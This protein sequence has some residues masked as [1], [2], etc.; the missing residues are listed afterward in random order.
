MRI[1]IVCG[2]IM[3]I[4]SLQ[5]WWLWN[6]SNIYANWRAFVIQ[7]GES[8]ETSN[9][10]FYLPYK[11]I[12]ARRFDAS[13]SNPVD[14]FVEQR[15]STGQSINPCKD[16]SVVSSFIIVHYDGVES[17]D[18]NSHKTA[19]CSVLVRARKKNSHDIVAQSLQLTDNTYVRSHSKNTQR[20][21]R[22]RKKVF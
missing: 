9:C 6:E 18:A 22:S 1:L 10:Q 7:C 4:N 2:V 21:T 12:N 15:G 3:N 8:T 19:R 11:F 20:Q 14:C 16:I 5:F 17:H 13:I